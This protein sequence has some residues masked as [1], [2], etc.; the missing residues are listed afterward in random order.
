MVEINEEQANVCETMII[1][2]L[3]YVKMTCTYS[4]S[5]FSW[6]LLLILRADRRQRSQI[7]SFGKTGKWL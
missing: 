5:L 4:Y 6:E 2:M 1:F 7:S 3:I